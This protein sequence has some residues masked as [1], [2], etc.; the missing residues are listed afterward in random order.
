LPK[1]PTLVLVLLLENSR[2]IEGTRKRRR[3]RTKSRVQKSEMRETKW[4]IKCF[5]LRG[6]QQ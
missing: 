3:K 6:C 2:Q 5:W 4:E 1:E